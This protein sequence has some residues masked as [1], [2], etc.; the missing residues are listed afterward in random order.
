[1]ASTSPYL[2]QNYVYI[3][4]T[5]FGEVYFGWV[6]LDIPFLF[7]AYNIYFT[8]YHNIALQ[9]TAYVILSAI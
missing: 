3:L 9:T 8:S 4:C 1:M 7:L 6:D 2:M 5:Q